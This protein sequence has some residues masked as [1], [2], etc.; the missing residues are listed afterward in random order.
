MELFARVISGG[1]ESFEVR[2]ETWASVVGGVEEPR[3]GLWN[4][5]SRLVS[6]EDYTTH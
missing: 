6:E 5:F 1:V 4:L 2:R 3:W